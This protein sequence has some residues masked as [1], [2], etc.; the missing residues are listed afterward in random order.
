MSDSTNFSVFIL[1]ASYQG[2]SFIRSQ[3]ESIRKQSFTNWT[4]LISDDGSSDNTVK[5][6]KEIASLDPRIKV[7]QSERNLGVINNY[8]KLLDWALS[9]DEMAYY[10]FCDQD[11]VWN[12][13]KLELMSNEIIKH[14]CKSGYGPILIHSDL[15]VVDENLVKLKSS[16]SKYMHIRLGSE[17]IFTS[18]MFRN[19]VTGCTCIFNRVL[20]EA[21]FPIPNEARMHDW[22]FA[23]NAA[24]YG[25]VKYVNYSTILYRQHSNNTVGVK[26]FSKYL[27]DFLHFS[28]NKLRGNHEIELNIRQIEL[29]IQRVNKELPV[30]P[31]LLK[32]MESFF[33]LRNAGLAKRVSILW[34]L[35]P[36]SGSLLFSIVALTRILFFSS[37]KT[38]KE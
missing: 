19:H 33:Q 28:E 14:E 26:P 27:E 22:W 6:I 24:L 37:Q 38:A 9:F 23:L 35:W 5:I 32:K 18:L 20:V 11:D 10:C 17:C 8:N 2:E 12:E 31:S 13:K 25:E 4:L 7:R 30:R 34:G 1:L 16:Y 15:T 29:L 36:I 3:I 21:S